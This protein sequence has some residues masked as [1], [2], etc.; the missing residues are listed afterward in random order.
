MSVI[1]M[2]KRHNHNDAITQLAPGL[3]VLLESAPGKADG[4]IPGPALNSLPVRVVPTEALYLLT[5]RDSKEHQRFAEEYGK[6][7]EQ[8]R[9][10]LVYVAR[11][12]HES[13]NGT[14]ERTQ[15][16]ILE[17]FIYQAA[18]ADPRDVLGYQLSEGLQAGQEHVR[19]V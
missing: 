16:I 15:R 1:A 9:E 4:G 5:S 3:P 18:K 8:W 14:R 10:F 7:H 2:S 13:V 6:V 17:H 19:F 11:A 12:L